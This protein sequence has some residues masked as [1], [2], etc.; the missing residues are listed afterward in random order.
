MKGGEREIFKLAHKRRRK[1]EMK[2]GAHVLNSTNV[3]SVDTITE[4]Y[5]SSLHSFTQ[6]FVL[7]ATFNVMWG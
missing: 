6:S 1:W 5:K 4:L 3:V 7:I 2:R